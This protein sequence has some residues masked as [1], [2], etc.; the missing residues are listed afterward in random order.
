MAWQRVDIVDHGK[1][2][3][4]PPLPQKRIG[5]LRC[6]IHRSLEYEILHNM[7]KYDCFVLCVTILKRISHYLTRYHRRQPD[8]NETGSKWPKS[9]FVALLYSR[10][11][12]FFVRYWIPL[13]VEDPVAFINTHGYVAC[14]TTRDIF[15]FLVPH[16]HQCSWHREVLRFAS[17]G[18][19]AGQWSRWWSSLQRSFPFRGWRDLLET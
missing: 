2:D 5:G 11:D 1:K 19:L 4:F 9:L 14:W 3:G 13:S 8:N 6:L 12:C 7:S 17:V 10:H 18:A 16:S 15:Q